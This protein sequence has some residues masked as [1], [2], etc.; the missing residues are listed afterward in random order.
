MQFESLRNTSAIAA[1]EQRIATA[2]ELV[3]RGTQ[4]VLSI[5]VTQILIEYLR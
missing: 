2:Q 1:G 5:T 3:N 4:V